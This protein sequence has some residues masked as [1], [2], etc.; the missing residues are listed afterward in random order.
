M[1]D[2]AGAIPSC[3]KYK[4]APLRCLTFQPFPL[5]TAVTPHLA[6][7][8]AQSPGVRNQSFAIIFTFL[9]TEHALGSKQAVP[10]SWPGHAVGSS[11]QWNWSRKV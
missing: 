1:Q 9:C 11:L 7:S 3:L 10:G 4:I 2:A 6:E 8:K 5:G